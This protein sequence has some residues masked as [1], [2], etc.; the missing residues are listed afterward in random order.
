M[1]M[2]RESALV[3][4]AEGWG[5][6]GRVKLGAGEGLRPSIMADVVEAVLG[7]VWL[8]GG[9]EAANR[10]VRAHWNIDFEDAKDAKTR[11]QEL[12]QGAGHGLPVYDVVDEAGPAHERFF[13]VK[14]ACALGEAVGEGRSKQVAGADAAARLLKEL[15]G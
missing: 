9:Y 13:K 7:A 11:L 6:G 14:V 15:E 12:V 8:D 2:V 3:A 1:A 5:L 10:V 4:V